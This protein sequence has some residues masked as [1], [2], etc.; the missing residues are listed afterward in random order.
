MFVSVKP[1]THYYNQ[2]AYKMH[3]NVNTKRRG[4]KMLPKTKEMFKQFFGPFNK[5]L[6]SLLNDS[7]WLWKNV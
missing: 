5:E 2:K 3:S 7:R 4:K 1:D 6:S